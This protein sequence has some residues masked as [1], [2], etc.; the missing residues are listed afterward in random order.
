MVMNEKD[1]KV[2]KR[3][4]RR[5]TTRGQGELGDAL[6]RGRTSAQEKE[7][8]RHGT[9]KALGDQLKP[10]REGERTEVELKMSG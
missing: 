5:K 10:I 2:S 8:L 6:T 1:E 9:R 7:L 4:F 3:V